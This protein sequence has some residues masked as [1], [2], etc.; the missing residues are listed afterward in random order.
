MSAIPPSFQPLALAVQG[1][2]AEIRARGQWRQLRPLTSATTGPLDLTHNDYLGLRQDPTF[3]ER[4]WK[5]AARW[6]CGAGA[7]RLLGGEQ[8]IFA[9]LEADFARWKGA[10]SALFFSSGYA[11]NEALMLALQHE[12][13]VF[14]SDSLNHASLVDGMRL[15]RLSSEQKQI[16]RHNDLSDLERRLRSSPASIR[17]IITEGL[18]S[19]DG[20]FAPLREI[21][22]LCRRYDALLVIDEAHSLGVYG[23]RGAG[24][25]AAS[26][27]SHAHL[28]SVNPCGKA[29]AASGAFITGP[30]WFRDY[31]INTARSF[32]YSTGASPWIAAALQ[33]S[34]AHVQ[35]MDEGRARLIN[36]SAKLRHLMR[37]LDFD[38]G[39]SRSHIVPLMTGSEA[40]A[41]Q[42]E[43]ILQQHGVQARAIRPP[44]VP[45]SACRLRLSLHAGLDETDFE[46]LS[47]ALKELRHA[48]S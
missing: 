47:F 30:L 36:F 15:A 11:A 16:F 35:G 28:L 41:L 26:G 24:H 27:L 19:M 13:A 37:E 3:R 34:I 23:P 10:E 5:A 44:T 8:P 42:A 12:G 17:L 6:P 40:R 1:K 32:I 2:L 9:A 33:V 21:D 4:T 22:E 18:F 7:S 43:K 31:L 14:F 20:D 25:A 48:L 38:C 46:K 29:M 39:A 45:P